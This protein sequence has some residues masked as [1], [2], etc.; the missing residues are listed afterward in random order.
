MCFPI[1]EVGVNLH[2]DIVF[3]EMEISVV[4]E[5]ICYHVTLII[6][7]ESIVN[8]TFLHRQTLF[9]IHDKIVD[10]TVAYVIENTINNI[11]L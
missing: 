7:F 11:R 9:Y 8:I 3:G 5:I 4:I 1:D 6:E 2:E 10:V